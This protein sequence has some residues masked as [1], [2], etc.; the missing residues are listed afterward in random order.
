MQ[1]TQTIIRF[2]EISLTTR[3][4]HKLRGYFGDLFR[5]HSPLLHNHFEDGRLRYA[6][7]LIQYKV[8]DNMPA[9]IG[10]SE[11][12]HLLTELFLKIKE[13]RI[14]A[15]TYPVF[16]KNISQ[17]NHELSVNKGLYN[18]TFK[19]LW[20]GL[21]QKNFQHYLE[22]PEPEKKG[23]LDKTVQNNI[24]SFYK[25]VG[26]RVEDRILV[27]GAFT[28]KQTLFKDKKMI[29]FAGRFSCNAF[30]PGYAGIG[31]AVSRGFGTVMQIP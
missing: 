12:A 16:S 11:G 3:D 24:L 10:F 23:F 29:A 14:G 28:E 26:F 8:V 27:N 22:L 9:L 2:P 7:P 20:M 30:L 17:K 6:Y 18:F 13:I 4:A 25:G 21:N 1:L 15:E 31:K 5:E 19:T